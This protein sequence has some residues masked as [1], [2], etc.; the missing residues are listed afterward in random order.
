LR[1]SA[2][3]LQ[4]HPIHVKASD[5]C[6]RTIDPTG[7]TGIFSIISAVVFKL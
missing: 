6:L 4:L 7:L 2:L 5:Y 3:S 1:K